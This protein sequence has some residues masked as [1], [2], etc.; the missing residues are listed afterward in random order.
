MPVLFND[1]KSNIVKVNIIGVG[2][3][4]VFTYIVNFIV[5]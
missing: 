4:S 3:S 1:N 2:Y 5:L